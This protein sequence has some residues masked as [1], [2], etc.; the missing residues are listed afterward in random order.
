MSEFKSNCTVLS[1]PRKKVSGLLFLLQE[2]KCRIMYAFTF[3][4]KKQH[5]LSELLLANKHPPT[6][7]LFWLTNTVQKQPH[8][9]TTTTTTAPCPAPVWPVCLADLR[10]HAG[11]GATCY[12]PR[13]HH[14][15]PRLPLGPGHVRSA[16]G[17]PGRWWWGRG[18]HCCAFRKVTAE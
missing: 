9:H 7:Y 12:Q 10:Q 16:L 14:Q 3:Y 6:L 15:S 11:K 2:K 13:Q 17:E 4:P 18:R 8:T 5:N 1:L